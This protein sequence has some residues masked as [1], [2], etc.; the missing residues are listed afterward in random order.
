MRD[1]PSRHLVKQRCS[2]SEYWLNEL[3]SCVCTKK[4]FQKIAS[5]KKEICIGDGE[6]IGS[7]TWEKNQIT[8]PKYV[9]YL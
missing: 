8:F 5:S 1:E 7:S 9:R 6:K 3:E 4:F 2:S